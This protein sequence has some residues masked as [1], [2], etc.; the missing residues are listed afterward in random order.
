LFRYSGVSVAQPALNPALPQR[1]FVND[2]H[3]L[4]ASTGF[5]V[6]SDSS[7]CSAAT[8]GLVYRTL[9]GGA[10]W[11]QIASLG[12][13]GS[14]FGWI[15]IHASDA[16]TVW[17]NGETCGARRV[18]QDPSTGLWTVNFASLNTTFGFF[19]IKGTNAANLW[20]VGNFGMIQRTR[21]GG[22]D[23]ATCAVDNNECTRDLC[24]PETG[25]CIKPSTLAACNDGTLCTSRDQCQVDAGCAGSPVN[26]DD[27]NPCTSNQC[28]PS[29]GCT[30]PNIP[31]S[32]DDGNSCTSNDVCTNG[33]CQGVG[34]VCPVNNPCQSGTCSS[35]GGCTY[36]NVN[37]GTSCNDGNACTVTDQCR[38][39]VCL[40]TALNCND[41]NLCTTDSCNSATGCVNAVDTSR[42]CSTGNQ[43]QLNEQCLSDG[44]CGGG[45]T[46]S[47]DDGN[48]CTG[49][50]CSPQSGCVF[51]NAD[52][53][54]CDD[55]NSCTGTD[56]CQAGVC[57]GVIV[58][59]N[60]GN[61]CTNDSCDPATGCVHTNAPA[62]TPCTDS[63]VCTT[64]DRCMSGICVPTGNLTCNDGNVCTDDSCNSTTGCAFT[65]VA[66]P[67]ACDDGN[68]CSTGD[69]CSAGQ[70]RA[71]GGTMCDDGNPCT[72]DSCAIAGGSTCQYRPALNTACN[73]NDSCTVSEMC[74]MFVDGGVGC[75]GVPLNCDDGNPCTI[76]SCGMGGCRNTPATTSISCDD[77]QACTQ[78]DVCMP[79]ADGG[80]FCAGQPASC[81][82]QNPCTADRCI[83]ADGGCLSVP[84]NENGSCNDQDTCTKAD[85]CVNGRC[86]GESN[87]SCDDQ[88]PCTADRCD[89]QSGLCVSSPSE[90]CDGGVGGGVADGGG[91]AQGG[92]AAGG[93]VAA[94]GGG[95]ASEMPTIFKPGCGCTHLGGETLAFLAYATRR[96][97]TTSSIQSRD[98]C[99]R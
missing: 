46:R 55:K 99:K 14:C 40:G 60:D 37:D 86:V 66:A 62:G 41:G 25:A 95:E 91:T 67:M 31:G 75:L 81:D 65:A 3:F 52:G 6:T 58:S 8:A 49:D 59:C 20:L 43:C 13:C 84:T 11:T 56:R 89:P 15:N 69:T 35:D 12:A 34:V 79:M 9:D 42:T 36:A 48:V 74:S 50:S 1:H 63:N 24:V 22:S 78:S 18:T 17:V 53:I 94:G 39:G 4:N 80:V 98:G 27:G 72:V 97:R 32:C 61:V 70:C 2:I 23:T 57:S 54:S 77:G 33:V 38:S 88:D 26:C 16:N 87:T 29:T 71:T 21:C 82:D 19:R 93:M 30:Y 92:G 96:R 5:F 28:A 10:N 85:V 73:D 90:A 47:C 44:R 64:G 76:D 83:A 51:S 68:P 7:G 45:S